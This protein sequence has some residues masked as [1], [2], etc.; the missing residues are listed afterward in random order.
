MFEL[1]EPLQ[2]TP[3]DWSI[4]AL[5]Q[6]S[7]ATRNAFEASVPTNIWPEVGSRAMSRLA[8]SNNGRTGWVELQKGRYR[9]LTS[10]GARIVVRFVMS[11]FLAGEVSW[12]TGSG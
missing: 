12:R 8:L 1:S 3:E 9:Y 2:N 7:A 10:W 11:E 4:R 5:D 6:L